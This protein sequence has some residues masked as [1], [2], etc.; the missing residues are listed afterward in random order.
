MLEFFR[1]L[2]RDRFAREIQRAIAAAGGPS[3][4]VYDRETF[5]L[6]RGETFANLGNVYHA[7]REAARAHRPQLIA[8][9][10]AAFG[11]GAEPDIDAFSAVESKLVAVVRERAFLATLEGPGWGLEKAVEAAKRPA[12]EP[13]TAWFSRALVIDYPT[14]VAI[15]NR[16]HLTSWGLTFEEAF[17][18]GLDRLRDGTLP[19]FRAE[20]GYYVGAWN[21]DYDSSRLLVPSIF[22]DIPLNGAPVVV[23][24]N[25]L[26]LMVVGEDDHAVLGAML[27]KAETIVRE[28]AKPQNPAPLVLRDGVFVDFTVPPASPIFNA[29]ERARKFAALSIYQDQ[30]ANLERCYE[31]SGKDIFVAAYT[32]NEGDDGRYRSFSV[33]S[34]GVAT[35]L[36]ETDFVLFV[37]PARPESKNVIGCVRW[38]AV[39]ANFGDLL[40]DTKMFPPRHYVSGFPALDQIA[41]L[42][43]PL[44]AE[45]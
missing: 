27:A 42:G 34:K 10:V 28:R 37:D 4:F 3:D 21:D 14:H 25:R 40:L 6:R 19:K 44:S 43:V 35:L 26:T 18:V 36:P 41:A 22:A 30:K 8:N 5:F 45:P 12:H 11:G 7:Y 29:V 39:A 38:A 33:W 16:A 32:L 24:P 9:F 15:V 13:I 1:Q 23:L 20:D 31:K 2:A 17:A